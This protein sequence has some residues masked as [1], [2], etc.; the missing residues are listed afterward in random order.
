MKLVVSSLPPTAGIYRIV[1]TVNGKC[2]VGSSKNIRARYKQHKAQLYAGTHHSAKLRNSLKKHGVSAFEF[3]VVELC[4]EDQLLIR[5]AHWMLVYNAVDCGYNVRRDPSTNAGVVASLETRSKLSR[6]HKG[7]KMSATTRANMSRSCKGRDMSE[8]VKISADRRRGKSLPK[9]TRDRISSALTG[10]SKSPE[11]VARAAEAQRGKVV[12]IETRKKISE[13]QIGKVITEDQ[14][15]KMR[16][17]KQSPDTVAKRVEKLRGIPHTKEHIEKRVA[18]TALAKGLDP[19]L[20]GVSFHKKRQQWRARVTVGG[21]EMHL[22]WFTTQ[23][24]AAKAR[25]RYAHA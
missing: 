20:R 6:L 18:A 12:S 23:E 17:R 16:G 15:A 13:A 21:K 25:A 14:K 10:V 24:D 22:G 2:Y 5:E 4:D 3:E 19:K 1:N 9:E 8:Q 7:R 11:H